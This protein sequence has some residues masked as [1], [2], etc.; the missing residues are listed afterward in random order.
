M[1]NFKTSTIKEDSVHT[2]LVCVSPKDEKRKRSHGND[3]V[4]RKI[5]KT[6]VLCATPILTRDL[7]GVIENEENHLGLHYV[8]GFI[9]H[10]F[11]KDFIQFKREQIVSNLHW[12]VSKNVEVYKNSNDNYDEETVLDKFYEELMVETTNIEDHIKDFTAI[13]LNVITQEALAHFINRRQDDAV[14]F[15][16]YNLIHFDKL[17]LYKA[18]C[19]MVTFE[20]VTVF[21]KDG[22]VVGELILEA[23]KKWKWNIHE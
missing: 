16:L 17:T 2:A 15:F 8:H 19:Y 13:I 1:S 7:I 4:F 10:W 5:K 23:G 11:D 6:S 22:V 14:A 3:G 9:K 18:E 12:W 20:T 21:E